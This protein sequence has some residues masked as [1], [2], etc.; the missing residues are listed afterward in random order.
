MTWNLK[1]EVVKEL[2][3]TTKWGCKFVTFIPNIKKFN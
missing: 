3:F 2:N 1:Y